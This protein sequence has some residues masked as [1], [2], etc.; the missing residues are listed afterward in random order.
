[1]LY[2]PHPTELGIAELADFRGL[3]SREEDLSEFFDISALKDLAPEEA[4]IQKISVRR[5]RIVAKA[6]MVETSKQ[7]E[8]RAKPVGFQI[9]TF[10]LRT[11]FL[12]LWEPDGSTPRKMSASIRTAKTTRRLDVGF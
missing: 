7:R 2:L 3:A 4:L 6:R 5:A 10:S 8:A 11:P 1:M 12:E 9:F